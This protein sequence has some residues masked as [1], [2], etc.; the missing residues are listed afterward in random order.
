MY[1]NILIVCLYTMHQAVRNNVGII[2]CFVPHNDKHDRPD[3]E[4]MRKS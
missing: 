3:I 2:L 4:D 1:S